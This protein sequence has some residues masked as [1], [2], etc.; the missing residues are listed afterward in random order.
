MSQQIKQEEVAQFALDEAKRLGCNDVSVLCAK[1]ND[2]QVRFA[3]NDITLVNNVR[4]ITLEVYLSKGKKRIVG[5]SFN[6]TED[7]IKRFLG[8]L[9]RSCEALPVSEDYVPLPVGP[10]RYKSHANFDPNVEDAP[11]VELVRQAIDEAGRAGA[12]RASGSLNTEVTDLFMITSASAQGADK[13]TQILLNIRAFADD[14]SSGQGLSCASYV[15]EFHPDRAGRKAGE[16]AKKSLGSKLVNEGKYDIVFSPTV[17]SNI[18]PVASSASAFAIESG[19]SF[20]VDKLGNKVA[21]DKLGVED[22]GV[23]DRGLGGRVFDDEGMPTGTNEIVLHGSFL[24]MLHNSSTAKKFGKEKSTGNAGIIFPRPAT[25]V[26]NEGDVSLDE[27]IRETGDGLFVTNNWYT[28][29][30]NM[31]SGD[32]ST[33][34]RDAAFRIED[35]E[36]GQPVAGFRLSDSIPRQ[37]LNIEMISNEREWIKWWEVSTPTLAPYM[38]IKDVGV[39]R[40]VGS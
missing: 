15:N 24:T 39:T 21:V 4:N 11:L 36:L 5:S 25:I 28:R 6:P 23:Y 26:F 34:P 16:Y 8:N 29:F 19:N 7:G 3:N 17:V 10:F 9:V 40:A 18:L 32:Y 37:L 12:L 14:N 30:Q 35:G 20:L 2:S 38:M 13:Q 33:V 22:Q 31:Q 27:M 1:S